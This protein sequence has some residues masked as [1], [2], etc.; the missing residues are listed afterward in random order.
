MPARRGGLPPALPGQ[1]RVGVFGRVIGFARWFRDSSYLL[2]RIVTGLG[3]TAGQARL[4]QP[5]TRHVIPPGAAGQGSSASTPAGRPR[6]GHRLPAVRDR[7]GARRREPLIRHPVLRSLVRACL[8]ARLEPRHALGGRGLLP[9]VLAHDLPGLP[10]CRGIAEPRR[11]PARC[12]VEPPQR[13]GGREVGD[14]ASWCPRVVGQDGAAQQPGTW[15]PGCGRA[16]ASA[17][18]RVTRQ[19]T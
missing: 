7:P 19:L 11:D 6:L 17:T 5:A 12:L 15:Q 9:L 8:G 14:R 10:H 4:R 1:G 2:T 16:H 13:C 3:S 18:R